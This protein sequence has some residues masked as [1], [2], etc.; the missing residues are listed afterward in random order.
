MNFDE[1]PKPEGF[2]EYQL[3]IMSMIERGR[4]SSEEEAVKIVE[5]AMFEQRIEQFSEDDLKRDA[6][7]TWRTFENKIRSVFPEL[8][9]DRRRAM[10]A[11]VSMH[12]CG[13]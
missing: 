3:E 9:E 5:L 12:L 13:M 6:D 8:P 4:A 11:A 10:K 7:G 2:S 1:P